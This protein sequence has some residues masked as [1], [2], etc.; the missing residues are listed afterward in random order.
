VKNVK[1]KSRGTEDGAIHGAV[2]WRLSQ[3]KKM[4][5]ADVQNAMNKYMDWGQEAREQGFVMVGQKLADD[6]GR[7][8]RGPGQV[9]TDGPFSETK[10][11]VGGYYIIVA[12]D[13]DEV[14][15]RLVNHP[16]FEYAGS[17]EI[18]K[19]EAFVSG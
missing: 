18:R 6:A 1:P 10:E 9:V 16:H 13:Y 19:I 2:I 15:S 14:V 7:V 4:S 12:A 11:V 17:M 5:S 3:W 8:V